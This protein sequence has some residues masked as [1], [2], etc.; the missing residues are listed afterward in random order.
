MNKDTTDYEISSPPRCTT[1][2]TCLMF[3]ESR[4]ETEDLPQVEYQRGIAL[5]RA[6]KVYGKAQVVAIYTLRRGWT[7][8]A[9]TFAWSNEPAPPRVAHSH[10]L[11][12]KPLH[13]LDCQN[14]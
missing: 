14:F 6:S 12:L 11:R 8:T 4:N 13:L 7:G 2:A 5:M 1:P 10:E 3:S 9:W